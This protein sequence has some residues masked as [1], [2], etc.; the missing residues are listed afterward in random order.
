MF[1]FSLLLGQMWGFNPIYYNTVPLNS[2]SSLFRD[3]G[4]CRFSYMLVCSP[5][6]ITILIIMLYCL[7]FQQELILF[8]Q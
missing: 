2:P 6:A 7:Q 3:E 8:M 5:E 1:T 4:F